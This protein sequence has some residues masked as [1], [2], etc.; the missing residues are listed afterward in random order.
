M[1]KPI[2]RILDAV[3]CKATPTA[4]EIILPCL[5]YND[6]IYKRTRFGSKKIERTSH[7]I[8]GR[9]GTSGTFLTGLLPRVKAYAKKN[10]VT[11]KI[12]GRRNIERVPAL[13][14]PKLKGITFRED[15]AKTLRL[16]KRISR[17][18]IIATTGSGK[19]I[20]ANGI[21]S[22]FPESPIL[23]LCHTTDLINQTYDSVK[24]YLPGR[25]VC[26]IGGGHQTD[27]F[28]L[29]RKKDKGPIVIATIQSFAKISP[30]H[31]IDFFDITIVDEVHHVNDK[32]SQY[33]SVM[34]CNLS[35]RRY[36]LTATAPK[37]DKEKLVN[38]GFFGPMISEL[39]M[40]EAIE[41]GINAKPVVHLH[42]VKYNPNISDEA[43]KSYKKFYQLGIV[44]N[45]TRN[46]LIFK[47]ARR[48]MRKKQPVLIIIEKTMHGHL[49]Q[50]F[51]TKKGIDVP[52]VYGKTSKQEREK[53]KN[54]LKQEKIMC[55]ICSRIWR[56]GTNIPSLR[57]IVNAHG[58]KEEKIIIQAMGR[59]LRT[60]KGKTEIKLHD[61]LD[62]YKFLAEHAILRIQVYVNQGWL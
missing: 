31:Y 29:I 15:Q 39:E 53:V 4:R 43:G 19:T 54:A 49:I 26:R 17:G 37:K 14:K 7:L 23:F 6:Y 56:E 1:G 41:K 10:G 36:G 11:L 34:E 35:P 5:A 62:P 8:T 61:F 60:F 33:G 50:K 45:K 21:F 42:P 22:M 48:A 59:G 57:H 27:L 58:M 24:K 30:E 51:F 18:N 16:V 9:K 46:K 44:E 3:H 47:L 52:F 32:K 28:K 38:E 13:K 40:D 12:V 20:I 55:A 25:M 2:I